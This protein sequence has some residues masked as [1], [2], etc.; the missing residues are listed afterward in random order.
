M[1]GQFRYLLSLSSHREKGAHYEHTILATRQDHDALL[2]VPHRKRPGVLLCMF[3]YFIFS[4]LLTIAQVGTV[5]LQ[6][7]LT[8]ATTE[9]AL[10][11]AVAES[12]PTGAPFYVSWR[13]YLLCL[14]K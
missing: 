6:T 7:V 12:F 3:L 8:K 13:S 10:I 1:H 5:T 2:Q 14:R 9:Q 11:E 4:T